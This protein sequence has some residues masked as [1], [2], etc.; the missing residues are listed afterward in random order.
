MYV[1]LCSQNLAKIRWMTHMSGLNTFVFEAPGK[2]DFIYLSLTALSL[3]IRLGKTE[4]K[5]GIRLNIKIN[6]F[7]IQLRS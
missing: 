7:S 5:P 3:A 4:A 1:G 2:D 6:S